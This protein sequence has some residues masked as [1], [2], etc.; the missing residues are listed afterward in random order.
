MSEDYKES[1]LCQT[2]QTKKQDLKLFRDL[3]LQSLKSVDFG[4]E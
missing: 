1:S 3:T 2:S 4:C